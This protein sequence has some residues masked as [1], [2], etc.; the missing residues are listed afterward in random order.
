MK[1]SPI[2]RKIILDLASN[3]EKV[4]SPEGKHI[5]PKGGRF[6]YLD[7]IENK[8]RQVGHVKGDPVGRTRVIGKH[9]PGDRYLHKDYLPEGIR[10]CSHH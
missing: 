3:R 10:D 1:Y 8:F 7:E 6:D 4:Y 5:G 9:M 2:I